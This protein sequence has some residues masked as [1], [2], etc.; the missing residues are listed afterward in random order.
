MKDNSNK[1]S[2]KKILLYY[3]ILAAC[4]LVIAAVTVTVIFT[5]KRP[6]SPNLTIDTNNPPPDEGNNKPDDDKPD[7]NKPSGSATDFL[8]PLDSPDASA[9][10]EF[11]YDETLDRYCVHQGLDFDGAAGSKVRAVLDGTVTKVVYHSTPEACMYGG[12]V[13]I[14]HANGVA[15]TYKFID[16]KDGLKVGDK[17]SR[18]DEIG[19]ISQATGVE[20]KQ[21][22]HLHFE[23]AVNGKPAN[24]E[25]YLEIIKK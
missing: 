19:A 22:E 6:H 2:K 16:V 4:L 20:F 24:P 5:V 15:T 18:G 9:T 1:K 7:D 17:V 12:H 11:G 10:Y 21:G 23:V 25:D 3:L 8:L 13:T 14:S